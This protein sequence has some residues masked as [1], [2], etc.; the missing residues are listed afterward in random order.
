MLTTGRQNECD[1]SSRISPYR[2]RGLRR[3]AHRIPSAIVPRQRPHPPS[4]TL[5]TQPSI[6][7]DTQASQSHLSHRPS[8]HHPV[9]SAKRPDAPMHPSIVPVD[10]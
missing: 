5:K 1:T 4:T 10:P 6:R 2:L 9:D 3:T 8:T 7:G